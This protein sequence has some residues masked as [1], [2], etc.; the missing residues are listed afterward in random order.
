[1][2]DDWEIARNGENLEIREPEQAG[3]VWAKFINAKALHLIGTSDL[4]VNGKIGIA[5]TSPSSDYRLHILGDGLHAA[6]FDGKVEINNELHVKGKINCGD[7][8]LGNDLSGFGAGVWGWSHQRDGVHGRSNY[9]NAIYGSTWDGVSGWNGYAGYFDG[10]VRVLSY[11]YKQGSGFEI[12]HRL[13]PANKYLRHSFVESSDMLN[14]YNGNVILDK[15]GEAWIDLPQWFEALNKDFRYQVTCIASYAPVY[16]A[17]KIAKN[18]FKIAGGSPQMEVS[19][20]VTG[21]RRDAFAKAHPFQLEVQKNDKERENYLCPEAHS[22]PVNLAIDHERRKEMEQEYQK[23][24]I[25]RKQ[26][27]K[28]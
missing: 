11:L 23:F 18:R 27:D 12:D 15:N 20:Q 24:I 5:T 25:E 13:D 9:G 26:D 4:W 6:Y 21:I 17:E 1:M 2:T 10:P 8:I 19:W 3:K 22:L 7:S 16:I 14:F 28:K